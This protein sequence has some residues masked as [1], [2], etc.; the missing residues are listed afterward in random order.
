MKSF[1]KSLVGSGFQVGM[2]ARNHFPFSDADGTGILEDK[3]FS[4]LLTS[5]EMD[6]TSFKIS[7]I[8]SP[9][10]FLFPWEALVRQRDYASS[11]LIRCAAVV[12]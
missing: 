2:R 7:N 10:L 8:S 12:Q 6:A 1:D 5:P 4:L 9:A 11:L 3:S